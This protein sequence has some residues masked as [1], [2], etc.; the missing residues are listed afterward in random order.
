[1]ADA[2]PTLVDMIVDGVNDVDAAD[3][4]G[5]LAGDSASAD[6]IATRLADRLADGA[7]AASARRRLAQALTDV[8]GVTASRALADLSR[9]PD[10]GVAL[11][12]AYVLQLRVEGAQRRRV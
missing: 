7:T 6:R 10:R 9:D 12:A 2:V 8:P 11:T 4:L 3:A 1:V 5:T